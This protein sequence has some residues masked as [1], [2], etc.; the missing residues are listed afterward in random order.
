[1]QGDPVSWPHVVDWASQILERKSKDLTVAAYM[2]L[3]LQETQGAMGLLQGAELLRGLFA[4]FW[5][6]AFPPPDKK[7]RRANS[8]QWW[9]RRAFDLLERQKDQAQQ[10]ESQ[11]QQKAGETPSTEASSEPGPKE[12]APRAA[13]GPKDLPSLRSDFTAVALDYGLALRF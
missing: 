10:S 12:A 9:H 11:E 1:M 2:A 13:Q 3:G 4:A 6:N 5:D 8:Y 7:R